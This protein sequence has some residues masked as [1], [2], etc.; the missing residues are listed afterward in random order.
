V[1]IAARAGCPCCAR[2]WP[3]QAVAFAVD[4]LVRIPGSGSSFVK[5]GET[6]TVIA[7]ESPCTG[8]CKRVVRDT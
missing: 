4:D 6:G 8:P 5:E 1:V 7:L 2:V 3:G